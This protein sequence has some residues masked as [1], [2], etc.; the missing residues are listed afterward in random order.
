M[1]G[2]M[3]FDIGTLIYI[4]ITIV[5]IA[6]GAFGKKKKPVSKPFVEGE[7]SESK[8]FFGKLEEQF[9]GFI[10]EA[11]GSVQN[12]TSEFIPEEK[13]LVEEPLVQS[14]YKGYESL[15][16]KYTNGIPADDSP[17]QEFEGLFDSDEEEN[18]DLISSEAIRSNEDGQI[19]EVID[20]DPNS[21]VDYDQ[22]IRNFDLGSAVIYSSIINRE[23]Y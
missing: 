17:L 1:G 16:D 9:G 15:L 20:T 7:E 5:A 22:M 18:E 2:K 3:D 23:E 19:M 10:E 11:K 8:G 14:D 6:A 21:Y 13:E 4:I 12:I